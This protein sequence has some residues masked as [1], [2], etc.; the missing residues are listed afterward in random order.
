M[1]GDGG[2]KREGGLFNIA[3]CINGSKVSRG[4]TCGS[5]ALYCFFNNKKMVT[6][7]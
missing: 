7:N 3:K 1:D 2:L 6:E 5:R 4:Q